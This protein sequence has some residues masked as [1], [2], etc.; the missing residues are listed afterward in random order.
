MDPFPVGFLG[1]QIQHNVKSLLDKLKKINEDKFDRLLMIF[2]DHHLDVAFVVDDPNVVALLQ[3]Q[4]QRSAAAAI[5][6][7]QSLHILL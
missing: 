3:F 5:L 6:T 7:S 2:Y 4:V 1:D